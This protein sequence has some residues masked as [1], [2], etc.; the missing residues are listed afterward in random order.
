MFHKVNNQIS[1]Q[2]TLN[3]ENLAARTI[4]SGHLPA[5]CGNQVS[6]VHED[7]ICQPTKPFLMFIFGEIF[8]SLKLKRRT[9]ANQ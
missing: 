4:F 9:E 1:Y 3:V 2:K 5:Q 7:D 8:F 6:K